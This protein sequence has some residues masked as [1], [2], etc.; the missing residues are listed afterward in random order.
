MSVFIFGGNMNIYDIYLT[1]VYTMTRIEFVGDKTMYKGLYNRPAVVLK[2]QDSSGIYF[3]DLLSD[4][5]I[6]ASIDKCNVGEEYINYN[7]L[8]EP[9]INYVDYDISKPN[10]SKRKMLKLLKKRGKE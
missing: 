6:K 7:D 4:K 1:K 10:I 8:Y 2:R 9:I 5:K 3:Y